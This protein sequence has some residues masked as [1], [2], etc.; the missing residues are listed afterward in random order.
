M[1]C[2]RPRMPPGRKPSHSPAEF[3][4]AAIELAD[5]VGIAG[6]TVRSLGAR[7]SVSSTAVYRYFAEK[8]SLLAAMRDELLGQ[9]LSQV[10]FVGDP[11]DQILS[12]AHA[13]RQTARTHPCLSHLMLLTALTGEAANRVP[14]LVEGLLNQMGIHGALAARGYRQFESLV[15][16][17]TLFDYSGAPVHLSDRLNRMQAAA[18]IGMLSQLANETDVEVVNEAAFNANLLAVMESLI[19]ESLQGKAK[20][21]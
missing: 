10:S 8:E 7:M 5:D 6:V 1:A 15:V 3:V 18:P 21:S 14:Q 16:G 9:V 12:L 19:T 4:S 13:Y 20:N 2:Y 17:T 11:K